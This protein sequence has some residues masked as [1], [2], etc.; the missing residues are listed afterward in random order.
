MS[1]KGHFYSYLIII[2]FYKG[3]R[4]TARPG[5][6]RNY[7]SA[8]PDW[9]TKFPRPWT[10]PNKEDLDIVYCVVPVGTLTKVSISEAV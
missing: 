1:K 7:Q 5:L 4:Q 3:N 2:L 10:R 6:V 9:L 8:L